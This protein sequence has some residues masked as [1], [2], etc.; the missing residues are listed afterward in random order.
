MLTAN[1]T[2]VTAV[3]IGAADAITDEL[4]SHG[5]GTLN[6]VCPLVPGDIAWDECDCGLLAQSITQTFPSDTFPTP[7]SDRANTA[8]GP[9]L[10]VVTVQVSITRCA[11]NVSDNGTTPSCDALR[12]AA[13]TLECDRQALRQGVRCYLHTLRETYQIAEYSVGTV[14]TQ[15]P[16]GGCVGVE[17]IYQFAV[18]NV[19]CS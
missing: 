5:C 7:A 4:A 13:V 1:Y 15:G 2:D 3:V 14:T 6:R 9:Q 16:Q 8:C 12:D 19:C 11:P 17:L 18:R 10:H